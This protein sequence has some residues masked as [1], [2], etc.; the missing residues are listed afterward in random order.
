MGHFHSQLI[1]SGK[2][3]DLLSCI[4]NLF[5]NN[6]EKKEIL[7]SE[8]ANLH[9]EGKI[10]VVA[11]FQK[12]EPGGD[13]N[14]D[15]FAC[16]SIFESVVPKLKTSV[17]PVL[18]C[19]M[20]LIQKAGNDMTTRLLIPCLM[21]FLS[22]D[23]DKAKD[24]LKLTTAE[25]DLYDLIPAALLSG[26]KLELGTFVSKAIELTTHSNPVICTQ[27]IH[28]LGQMHYSDNPDLVENAF[29][30][31][32]AISKS[33]S[34]ETILAQ[35]LKSAF[36]LYK[37]SPDKEEAALAII[38]RSLKGPN[39][40]TIHAASEIFRSEG[41][42]ISTA[43]LSVLQ[44]VLLEVDINNTGTMQ[45]IDLGLYN[46][47]LNGK[48]DEAALFLEKLLLKNDDVTL[49]SKFNLF[50][51]E[52]YKDKPYLNKLITR[53]LLS[54]RIILCRAAADITGLDNDSGFPL[55]VDLEQIKDL[56]VGVHLFLA[57]KACGWFFSKPISAASFII[58]L[59][60][61]A[62]DEQIDLITEDLFN[63]LIISYPG[64]GKKYLMDIA[65][66]SSKK[67]NDVISKVLS[68]LDEHH[69]NLKS[70]HDI[71]ELSPSLKQID[72]HGLYMG[73]LMGNA[74]EEAQKTSIAELLGPPSVLLY[75]NSSVY[76]VNQGPNTPKQRQET[77]MQC[78]S[79]EV[80]YPSLEAL[81][82][83][84]LDHALWSFKTEGGMK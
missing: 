71:T 43:V 80:E 12:I 58:S 19:S 46:L 65:A 50:T 60:D 38:T 3:D 42:D 30:S 40:L 63:P 52:A 47:Y 68:L 28:S 59:I 67:V 31:I 26:A 45:N 84:G 51:G 14:L 49:L 69:D 21:E 76:Y 79:H 25:P 56:N 10:D 83:H 72:T 53:W 15:F 33:C 77:Q 61:T 23:I 24:A 62:N 16:K 8:I 39:S 6:S 7:V 11:A 1:E 32:G 17:E 22:S 64:V 66:N 54:K 74:F 82:P 73:K 34:D 20:H 13:S 5:L 41:K 37:E 70:V 35:L 55:K 36:Y 75:G 27:A 81:D 48:K 2:S 9:N 18:K 29:D 4:N 78:F 57:R 44:N